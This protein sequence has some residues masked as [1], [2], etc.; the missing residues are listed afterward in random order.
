MLSK[1]LAERSRNKWL[2]KVL[3][4]RSVVVVLSEIWARLRFLLMA[5]IVYRIGAHILVPVSTLID[6]DLFR[7]NEGN[8]SQLV[9]HVFWRRAGA[10]EY[11]CTGIMP[12]I[13][14]S[15][16]MQLMTAVCTAGAVEEGR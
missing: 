8:H 2:S 4:Q 13:P 5:I 15:I 11:F 14:A 9:Q 10:Y 16:I 1:Q 3:S 6:S 12:Y 7:Q